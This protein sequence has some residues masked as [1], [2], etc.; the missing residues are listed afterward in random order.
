MINVYEVLLEGRDGD[1]GYFI[2]FKVSTK[3]EDRARELS[4]Q[5]AN[6]NG[7]EIVNI[8]EVENVGEVFSD[9]EKAEQS[10]GKSYFSLE[11]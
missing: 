3:N 11:K 10:S 8:E 1:Q 4:L 9:E 7:L 6:D 2:S 5:K